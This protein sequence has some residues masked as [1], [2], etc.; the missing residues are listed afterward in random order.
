MYDGKVPLLV[1][2]ATPRYICMVG[3]HNHTEFYLYGGPTQPHRGLFVWWAN[4]TTH[5]SIC[6]VGQHNHIEVYLYGGP[7]QPHRA[8]FV[9]WANT[10]T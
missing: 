7:T 9:W 3:Q 5:S 10:T 1:W 6:M 2:Y 4:T 8:L